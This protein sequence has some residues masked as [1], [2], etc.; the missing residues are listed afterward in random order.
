MSIK[1][2]AQGAFLFATPVQKFT[3]DERD[4]LD[5]DVSETAYIIYNTT[6]AQ[7]EYTV[8]GTNWLAL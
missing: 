3:T 1:T 4:V 2:K 7:F 6:T 5:L 8:D